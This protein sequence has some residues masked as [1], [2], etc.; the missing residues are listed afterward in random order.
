MRFW[1]RDGKCQVVR[2]LPDY[3]VASIHT[4]QFTV[5]RTREG[6]RYENVWE[7]SFSPGDLDGAA[8]GAP[9]R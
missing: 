1:R 7:S 8:G 5:R 6:V 2:S 4:G 9:P 3:G